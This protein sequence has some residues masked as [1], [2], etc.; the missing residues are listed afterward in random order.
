MWQD[1]GLLLNGSG[2]MAVRRRDV[3]EGAPKDAGWPS[4]GSWVALGHLTLLMVW[5]YPPGPSLQG[6]DIAA[7]RDRP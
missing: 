5:L 3:K 2:Y 1:E 6:S 7:G 4:W